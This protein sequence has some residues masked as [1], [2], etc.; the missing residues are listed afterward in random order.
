L[1]HAIAKHNKH[2][3]SRVE[4]KQIAR[5]A[6]RSAKERQHGKDNA[7]IGKVAK[8]VA[9]HDKRGLSRVEAR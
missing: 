4:A 2:K 9:E 5:M 3:L 6:A 7:S 1:K 8:R